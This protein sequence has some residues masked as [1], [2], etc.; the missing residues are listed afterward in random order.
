MLCKLKKVVIWFVYS[1]F[2]IKKSSL[3][4]LKRLSSSTYPKMTINKMLIHECFSVNN[5]NM[6]HT[7]KI[8]SVRF[9]GGADISSIVSNIHAFFYIPSMKK[10]F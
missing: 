9:A 2:I 5:R 10:P 8:S 1:A 3:R 7:R 4:S 6:M